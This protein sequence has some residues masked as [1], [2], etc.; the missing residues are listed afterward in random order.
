MKN[1]R[2]RFW[3]CLIAVAL[4]L[5][6]DLVVVRALSQPTVTDRAL[7]W[8]AGLSDEERSHYLREGGIPASYFSAVQNSLTHSGLARVLSDKFRDYERSHS[9][10]STEQRTVL[11]SIEAMLKSGRPWGP[12]AGEPAAGE[13]RSLMDQAHRQFPDPGAHAQLFRITAINLVDREPGINGLIAQAL[14]LL[15]SGTVYA[16]TRQEEWPPCTCTN[17][18]GQDYCPVGKHCCDSMV[19]NWEP[20]YIVFPIVSN[21]CGDFNQYNCNGRCVDM[22]IGGRP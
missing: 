13:F 16:T 1:Q 3:F 9:G 6:I 14:T 2:R 8:A 20:H 11:S 4:A 18:P 10:L 22:T 12:N 21:G 19:C 15:P 17:F 7:S 5:P